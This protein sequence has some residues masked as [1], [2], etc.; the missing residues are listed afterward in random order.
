[1]R[2][3]PLRFIVWC[4]NLH[5]P[6]G[7]FRLNLQADEH[8]RTFILQDGIFPTR[9][10]TLMW[11][12]L[13]TE[14]NSE[15]GFT[16]TWRYRI[17]ILGRSSYLKIHPICHWVALLQATLM[18]VPGEDV[19]TCVLVYLWRFSWLDYP[20]DILVHVGILQLLPEDRSD[21]YHAFNFI[22]YLHLYTAFMY[23]C[24]RV[25]AFLLLHPISESSP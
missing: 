6:T 9:E 5:Q 7:F 25:C 12:V 18:Q 20:L 8:T 19:T 16:P 3:F 1:M 11:D 22:Y 21:R 17:V 2:F 10:T 24:M 15:A 23:C 14:D 13:H 4:R